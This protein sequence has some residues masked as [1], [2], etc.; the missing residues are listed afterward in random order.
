MSQTAKY[1]E[2]SSLQVALDVGDRLNDTLDQV[3]HLLACLNQG[4]P[5]LV[6]C[7]DSPRGLERKRT[8]VGSLE[9]A[10][11]A[12]CGEGEE[13]DPCWETKVHR[14]LQGLHRVEVVVE[15]FV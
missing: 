3:V 2:T 1:V 7:G 14:G 10:C 11:A 12:K 6:P 15:L 8:T 9:Q 5:R 13:R 4:E